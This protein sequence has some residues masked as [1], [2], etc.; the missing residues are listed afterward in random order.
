L[1][2]KSGTE[3]P[4]LKR[5]DA[6]AIGT[7]MVMAPWTCSRVNVGKLNGSLLG[8]GRPYLGWDAIGTNRRAVVV[9]DGAA[10]DLFARVPRKH[11]VSYR[12]HAARS[13]KKTAV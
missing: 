12:H 2:V 7:R 8:T 5:P 6:M 11:F 9:G 3:V 1:I 13:L 10:D 4:A